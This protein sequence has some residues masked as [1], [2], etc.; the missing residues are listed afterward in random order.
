MS[1]LW[2]AR[3]ISKAMDVVTVRRTGWAAST[4]A[5]KQAMAMMRVLFFT[6]RRRLDGGSGLGIGLGIGLL[7]DFEEFFQRLDFASLGVGLSEQL[8]VRFASEAKINFEE[9][10]SDLHGEL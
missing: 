6:T 8:R 1:R 2:F 3:S 4:P 9:L 5:K 10:G 7:G